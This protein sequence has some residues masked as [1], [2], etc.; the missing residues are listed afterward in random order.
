MQY[1]IGTDLGTT[2][3]KSVLYD[4][5]GHVIASANVGYPLYHDVPD[6]AEEDPQAILAAVKKQFSKSAPTLTPKTLPVLRFHP[7]CTA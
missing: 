1:M 2:S 7:P 4:L 6:M 5:A 3:T